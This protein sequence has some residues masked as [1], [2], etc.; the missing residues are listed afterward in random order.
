[1]QRRKRHAECV[2]RDHHLVN[3]IALSTLKGVEVEAQTCGHDASEHRVSTAPW[4]NWTMD[5]DIDVVG[6]EIGFLHDAS[7]KEAG[8][9]HSLSP[10]VPRETAR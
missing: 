8:A 10:I 3:V 6:Q 9:Q 2:G 5:D 4:T 7:L 1:M